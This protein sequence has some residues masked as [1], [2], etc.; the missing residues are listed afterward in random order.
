MDE[1]YDLRDWDRETGW[2]RR[3]E[4]ERLGLDE[5]ADQLED[6]RILPGEVAAG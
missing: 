2:P 5:V 4:L 3:S 6:A 1:Y